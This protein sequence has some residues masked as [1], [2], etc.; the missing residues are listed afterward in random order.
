MGLRAIFIRFISIPHSNAPGLLWY[1]TEVLAGGT[2]SRDHWREAFQPARVVAMPASRHR[3]VPSPEPP[4]AMTLQ[5]RR[6]VG[7][8]TTTRA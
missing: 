4:E 8:R 3:R 7:H 6:P 2:H 5:R 1:G